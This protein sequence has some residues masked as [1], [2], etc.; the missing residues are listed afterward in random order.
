MKSYK[1]DSKSEWHIF[2]ILGDDCHKIPTIF[3]YN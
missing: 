2:V 1:V 3:L